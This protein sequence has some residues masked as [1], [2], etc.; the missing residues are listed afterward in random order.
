MR[1]S[2][3][4]Q[5]ADSLIRLGPNLANVYQA[6]AAQRESWPTT[7]E[8][9]RLGLGDDIESVTTRKTATGDGLEI[10]FKY[11]S[12][13]EEVPARSLSDGTLD[14]LAFVAFFRL[15][16]KKSLVVF[17]EP[18][19]QLHPALATRVAQLFESMSRIE[20][21]LVA[22]HSDRF[23]DALTKPAQ[24]VVLCSLDENRATRLMRPEPAALQSWLENYRGLGDLRAVGHEPSVMTRPER[25]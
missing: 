24:S 8:Y 19:S 16:T 20:T 9:I 23:L 6:L 5:S 18:E 21:L 22:T 3:L 4:H 12:F 10:W 14:Y 1:V 15:A 11:L 13:P 2:S 17:D 7:M 25:P